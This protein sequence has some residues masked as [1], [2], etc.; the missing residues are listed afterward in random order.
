ME[1]QLRTGIELLRAAHRRQVEALE[2]LWNGKGE[3]P[4]A[5]RSVAPTPVPRQKTGELYSDVVGALAKVP[6]VFTRDDLLA[7]LGYQPNRASLYRIL[8]DL[9][10]DGVLAT[11]S[12]GGGR[13][14]SSYRKT[15]A[16]ASPPEG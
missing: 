1:E 5:A 9:I 11:A 16:A 12:P 13:T 14:P 10:A 6:D 8:Q 2:V 3:K 15:K 7:C 4:V